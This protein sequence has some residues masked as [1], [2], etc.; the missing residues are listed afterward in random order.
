MLGGFLSLKFRKFS[1]EN[2]F[3][4]LKLIMSQQNK[5]TYCEDR[6]EKYQ[7]LCEPDRLISL[8]DQTIN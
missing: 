5:C 8:V 4:N 1:P 2:L 6:G 7:L 3:L